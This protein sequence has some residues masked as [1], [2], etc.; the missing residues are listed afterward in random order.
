MDDLMV[1]YLLGQLSEEEQQQIE[2]RAFEDD[3]FYQKLLEVEDE[4]RCAYAQGTLPLAQKELFE[5]R[6]LIFADE[7]GRVA[8]ARDMI[9]ELRQ[10]QV[11][12]K[13]GRGWVSRVFGSANPGMRFAMAAASLVIV[14]GLVWLLFETVRMRGEIESLRAERAA[15][16]QQLD[17][18]LAQERARTEQLDKQL[19]EERDRRAQLEQE[20]AMSGRQAEEESARPS[21]MALLLS[22]GRI[23]GGGETKRLVLPPRVE[24][25][26][27]GLELT[28]DVSSGY[29]AVLMN[30]EGNEIWSK[31]ALRAR[32]G[33]RPVIILNIPA[34][35]LAEDDYELRL[36]GLDPA[37]QP[38][39]ADGYYFTVL[40]K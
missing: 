24:Q 17:K 32:R 14:A 7:R 5:K 35:I 40:K 18:R 21:V 12:R 15:A 23:R 27:L 38:E 36:T 34:H 1:R 2:Q 30:S 8:L 9:A 26:R 11:E 4:L 16:E 10:A 6:F 13:A 28:G 33:A 39:L 29:R 31:T 20:L 25:L 3:V 37:G 19:W 22:P